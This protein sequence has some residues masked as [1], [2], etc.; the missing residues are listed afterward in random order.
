M[1]WLLGACSGAKTR[2]YGFHCLYDA[3][4]TIVQTSDACS[5]RIT[6]A[7]YNNL[8]PIQVGNWMARCGV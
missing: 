8:N 5:F 4:L 2:Y 6:Q 1:I 3:L 7:F